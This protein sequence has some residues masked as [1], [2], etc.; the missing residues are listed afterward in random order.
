MSIVNNSKT[1]GNSQ[2]PQNG[3]DFQLLDKKAASL[4]LNTSIRQIHN[5]RQQYGLPYLMVGGRVMFLRRS[6]IAWAKSRETNSL[7]PSDV[8]K[9]REAGSFSS[10]TFQNPQ[11]DSEGNGGNDE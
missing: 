9:E 3:D 4:L 10:D 2:H 1:V 7:T 5:L 6:L 8:S 11:S